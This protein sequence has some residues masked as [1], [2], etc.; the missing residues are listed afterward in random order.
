MDMELKDGNIHDG[1]RK[2][3]DHALEWGGN[4]QGCMPAILASNN[5]FS[6]NELSE[7]SNKSESELY[8]FIFQTLMYICKRARPDIEP[9]LSY[10][11]RKVSNPREMI[12]SNRQE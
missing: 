11:S 1:M 10:L 3:I 2:Q 4:Q 8:H 12:R 7:A 9:A 6:N 5:L